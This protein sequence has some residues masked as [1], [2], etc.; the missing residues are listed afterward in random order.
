MSVGPENETEAATSTTELVV[1]PADPSEAEKARPRRTIR[2][3]LVV[4]L[5]MVVLLV[6]VAVVLEVVGR[7][8]ATGYVREGIVSA[9]KLPA[10]ATVDVDLGAGSVLLQAARGSF[11]TVRVH[12]PA[13]P[14]DAGTGTGGAGGGVGSIPAEA[15]IIASGVPTDM[16]QPVSA[17]AITLTLPESSVARFT[18]SLSG[19]TI[20]SMTLTEG[21]IRVDGTVSMLFVTVPVGVDLQPGAVAGGISF[22]PKT[23]RVGG[24]QL[25]VDDLRANPFFGTLTDGILAAR[26]VCV[27][28]SL[29]QALTFDSVEVVGSTLVVR[30]NA[31]GVALGDPRFSTAGTCP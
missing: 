16:T 30:L 6:M 11:D 24:N 1:V 22:T 23:V 3:W 9:L 29:P 7:Q 12:V 4:V 2:V 28:P 15:E 21:V 10:D 26:T 20:T 25:S 31:D 14:L 5:V 27:A 19:I 17:L 13:F 18:D 8:L